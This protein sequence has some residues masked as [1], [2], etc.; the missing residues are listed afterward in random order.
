M[1][2]TLH[3]VRRVHDWLNGSIREDL[4]KYR[5]LDAVRA[6]VS[7]ANALYDAAATKLHRAFGRLMDDGECLRT[8]SDR[9]ELDKPQRLVNGTPGWFEKTKYL[10]GN[11]DRAKQLYAKWEAA[12]DKLDRE[13]LELYR[14]M[15]AEA[16]TKWPE[17]L[18]TLK[19]EEGFDPKNAAAFRNKTI[20]LR[21][22]RNRTRW[23]FDGQY[24][25]A[26]HVD[27]IPVAGT[28]DLKIRNAL[29]E[30]ARRTRQPVDDHI[31]WDVVGVV[32]GTGTINERF[33]KDMRIKDTSEKLKVEGTTP[34]PC[35]LL[36]I[37]ALR[38]GPV[39]IGPR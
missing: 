8:P 11:V 24:D 19:I 34:K 33:E 10:Q 5:E 2:K 35:L 32:E 21:S 12:I 9:R 14:K 1:P 28:Y 39:A 29:G 6:I 18:K 4:E 16:A 37:V 31:D 27:G 3:A 25:F 20:L 15:E 23:D 7:E 13:G 26:M 22:V 36:R 17:I 38:A 30:A